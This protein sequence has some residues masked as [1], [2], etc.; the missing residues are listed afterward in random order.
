MENSLRCNLIVLS[1]DCFCQQYFY[2]KV[3][4]L[5]GGRLFTEFSF[6]P[7][8]ARL[9]MIPSGSGRTRAAIILFR[10]PISPSENSL[11]A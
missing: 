9:N 3:I 8:R 5:T 7:H 4:L 6:M 1:N 10:Q 11:A 2:R